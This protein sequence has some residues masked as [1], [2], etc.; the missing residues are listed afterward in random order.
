M[1][2]VGEL[3]VYPAH[4]VGRV[5]MIE[6]KDLYGR[7]QDFYVLKIL[8]N[9]M[10]II[11]PTDRAE[12]IG[13]RKITS[14]DCIPRV[15]EILNDRSESCTLE[16]LSW[17]RR[18]K[19]YMDKIKSG[20]LFEVAEVFRELLFLK[21]RKELSF[22]ERKVLDTARNLLTKELSIARNLQE[23]EVRQELSQMFC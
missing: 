10:K 7:K 2:R 22:G 1:F 15:Y 5:E 19:A 11:V 21:K 16:G 12:S 9:G 8:E 14:S 4:G 3:A 13:L 6:S 20:S 23:D 17:N 18:H